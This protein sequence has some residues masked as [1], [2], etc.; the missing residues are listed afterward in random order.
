MSLT[1]AEAVMEVI[2]ANGRQGVPRWLSRPWMGGWQ[3]ASAP[4][5]LCCKPER[6]PDRLDRLPEEDAGTFR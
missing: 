6:P 3:N 4:S 2:A 5:R 1:Q